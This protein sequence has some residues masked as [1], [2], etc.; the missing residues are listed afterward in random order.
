MQENMQEN[1]LY[2]RET[3][4]NELIQKA[5]GNSKQQKELYNRTYPSVI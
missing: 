4:V 3:A 2:V 5:H 1:D